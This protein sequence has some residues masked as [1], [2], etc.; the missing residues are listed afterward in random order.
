M[1]TKGDKE[2]KENYEIWKLTEDGRLI[3]KARE[4]KWNVC[5]VEK[6]KPKTLQASKDINWVMEE[7][8]LTDQ[9]TK[10]VMDIK[11]ENYEP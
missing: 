5:H 8:F 10:K 11:W 2:N 9:A 6:E 3:N 4:Q 1:F 7:G